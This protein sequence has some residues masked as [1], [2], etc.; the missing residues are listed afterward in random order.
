[1]EVRRQYDD[2]AM[3][4][5][6]P[7]PYGLTFS[8]PPPAITS[9][10]HGPEA[11]SPPPDSTSTCVHMSV[12]TVRHLAASSFSASRTNPAEGDKSAP[13]IMGAG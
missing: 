9:T 10:Q 4:V 13:T 6:A 7:A 8:P 1:M 5:F 3:Q 11:L 12:H 2:E